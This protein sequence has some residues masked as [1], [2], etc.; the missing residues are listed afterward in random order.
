M[1]SGTQVRETR[2][3]P[4]RAHA[5]QW[6]RAP[7]NP[8][9]SLGMVGRRSSFWQEDTGGTAL[10]GFPSSSGL[11]QRVH[12]GDYAPR[13]R[14]VVL[15]LYGQARR[16]RAGAGRGAGRGWGVPPCSPSPETPEKL[17]GGTSLQGQGLLNGASKS[18]EPPLTPHSWL[19]PVPGPALQGLN[20]TV[21]LFHST[22]AAAGRST[23]GSW[24]RE[25]VSACTLELTVTEPV[26]QW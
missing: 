3:Q 21:Y 17:C 6:D 7:G 25:T 10:E 20:L 23:L 1:G 19:R 2:P 11:R 9:Q 22:A 8:G 14:S 4:G 16:R 13:A 26:V 12:S 5:L 24:G 15:T 18:P